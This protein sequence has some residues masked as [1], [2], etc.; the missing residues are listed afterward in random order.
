MLT[1][2]TPL[3]ATY[4]DD[5]EAQYWSGLDESTFVDADLSSMSLPPPPIIIPPCYFEQPPSTTGP[6]VACVHTRYSEAHTQ[7]FFTIGT[8]SHLYWYFLLLID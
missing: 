4:E 7:V 5:D 3:L 6:L 1:S 2:T 8:T